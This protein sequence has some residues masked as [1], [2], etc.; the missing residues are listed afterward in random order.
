M[1][2][3]HLINHL[4]KFMKRRFLYFPDAPLPGNGAPVPSKPIRLPRL[5]QK[6]ADF[7]AVV[8]QVAKQWARN[9]KLI[10]LWT[11][12][13]EFEEKGVAFNAALTN[14]KSAGSNRPSQT[15]TLDSLDAMIDQG[16]A[17]AKI[18][19]KDKWEDQQE[20]VAQF[21]RYGIIKRGSVYELPR[22]RQDRLKALDLTIAA[23]IKDGFEQKP[24]G[25]DFWQQT[26]VQYKTTLEAAGNTDGSV[27]AE[28]STK[29]LLKA[30]LKEIMEALQLLIRAN[31]PQTWEAI[32]REWGWQKEDY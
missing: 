10:L 12:A 6:D 13:Q 1:V 8:T 20:A 18:Y 2:N 19:I 25:K 3:V 26:L 7:G 32:Y 5:P 11:D 31:Y 30:E 29:D 16:I 9:D 27:S 17:R 22:D 23:I 4:Q 14:R 24:F 28:V 15:Q 21:A